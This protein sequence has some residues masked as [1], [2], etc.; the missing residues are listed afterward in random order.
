MRQY[1]HLNVAIYVDFDCLSNFN[2][3]SKSRRLLNRTGLEEA[4]H[5]EY[6]SKWHPFAIHLV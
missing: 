1:S 4:E 3:P 5:W 2:R 6:I